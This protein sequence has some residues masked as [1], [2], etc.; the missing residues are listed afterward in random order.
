MRK[1]GVA[2]PEAYS[3][4]ARSVFERMTGQRSGP[5]TRS[6]DVAEVIWRAVNEPSCPVRQPAGATPL[7]WPRRIEARGRA[8]TCIAPPM[9]SDP[10]Q[11]APWPAGRHRRPCQSP[12]T[13]DAAR[14]C[15]FRSPRGSRCAIPPRALLPRRSAGQGLSMSLSDIDS[16]WRSPPC[17]SSS[18]AR[19]LC[20]FGSCARAARRGAPGRRARTL[21]RLGR[22]S[23]R[24]LPSF[25]KD[26]SQVRATAHVERCNEASKLRLASAHHVPSKV[27]LRAS[28]PAAHR[29]SRWLKSVRGKPNRYGKDV[30]L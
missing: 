23:S 8:S 3:D 25:A 10:R 26:S 6:L 21:R 2:V 30:P 16:L 13:L 29:A 11:G 15:G 27:T 24:S 17:V 28:V 20:W 1:Q 7:S 22:R 18:P 5:S 14:Y 9:L 12:L 4:F 19:R